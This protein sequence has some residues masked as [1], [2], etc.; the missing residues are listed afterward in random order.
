MMLGTFSLRGF[1]MRWWIALVLVI[2]TINPSGFSYFH[3]V[4]DAESS[5]SLPEL[6]LL[7]GGLLVV[8]FIVY[9]RA[10]LRSIG[11]VG[12]GLGLFIS[13]TGVTWLV[14]GGWLDLVDPDEAAWTALFVVATILGVGL[15]WSF[16]RRALSG[17]IDGTTQ[18]E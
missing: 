3:W 18:G 1:L 17:Q 9:G 2:G 16:I 13:G 11:V 15:S 4:T 8:G 12:I 10:T 14:R 5:H 6:K 7:I